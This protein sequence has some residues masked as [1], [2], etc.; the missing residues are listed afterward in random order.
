MGINHLKWEMSEG[1]GCDWRIVSS[2]S[3]WLQ[4]CVSCWDPEAVVGEGADR[5]DVELK[6]ELAAA[7]L[8]VGNLP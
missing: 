5:G 7:A 4:D 8:G 6:A 1:H 3:L 2:V